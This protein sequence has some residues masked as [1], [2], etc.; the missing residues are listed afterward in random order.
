MNYFFDEHFSPKLIRGLGSIASHDGDNA[1][2]LVDKFQRGISDEEYVNRLSAEGMWAIA[3]LDSHVT[4]V[5]QIVAAWKSAG[6]I[7]PMFR[8]SW[9]DL[10][11][12]TMAW[13][14]IKIWPRLRAIVNEAQP[15]SV[16]LVP[17]SGSPSFT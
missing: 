3:T 6:L 16:I 12:W 9:A 8:N 2:P 1:V 5:P 17:I 15:G 10:E 14:L 11:F 7:V 13:R 4:R